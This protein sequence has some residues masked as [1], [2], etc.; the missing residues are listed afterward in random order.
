MNHSCL[1]PFTKEEISQGQQNEGVENQGQEFPTQLFYPQTLE[2]TAAHDIC[3]IH[4]REKVG[5]NLRT[6]R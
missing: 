4:A 5:L 2:K 1:W 3:E 6:S